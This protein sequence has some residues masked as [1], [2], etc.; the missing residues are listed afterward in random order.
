MRL[1]PAEAV[2][3]HCGN[4]IGD[5]GF[6]AQ[7]LFQPFGKS[8]NKPSNGACD[9]ISS[10]LRHFV[11]K[12]THISELLL[13][14]ALFLSDADLMEVLPCPLL[15]LLFLEFIATDIRVIVCNV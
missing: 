4:N 9:L 6:H 10:W 1:Q 14:E 7:G 13:L 8:L 11:Q 15:F 12:Q 2:V 5:E 3:I